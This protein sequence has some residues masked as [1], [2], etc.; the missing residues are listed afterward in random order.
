MGSFVISKKINGEFKFE[1]A[2]R[3]GKTVLTSIGCKEKPDCERIIAAFQ[4]GMAQFAVTRIR[5]SSGKHFFRISKDGLV[6][7]NSR[8]F[9]TE[10]LMQ[11]GLTEFLEKA[12]IS[13]TLDFSNQEHVFAD[14]G[15]AEFPEP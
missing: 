13:E 5:Q 12:S 14:F 9:T 15:P 1:Y 10:L 3:R 6:L 2:S 7:A 8:K 4:E 11:K